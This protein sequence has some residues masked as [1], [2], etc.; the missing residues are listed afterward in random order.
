MKHRYTLKQ[1]RYSD[2]FSATPVKMIKWDMSSRYDIDFLPLG[3]FVDHICFNFIM[4]H[5]TFRCSA[6]FL[7]MD[8]VTRGHRSR[9]PLTLRVV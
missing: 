2:C 5:V 7:Y 9:V 1:T 3:T 6:D 8:K 4:Y